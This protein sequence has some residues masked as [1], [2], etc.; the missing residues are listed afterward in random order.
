MSTPS[1][2][3]IMLAIATSPRSAR[4]RPTHSRMDD[5]D[6]AAAADDDDD[7]DAAAAACASI[8]ATGPAG[9]AASAPANVARVRA[10]SMHTQ[11]C[12]PYKRTHVDVATVSRRADRVPMRNFFAGRALCRPP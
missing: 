6:D 4:P 2:T 10:E 1:S 5:D 8:A 7:V 3:H 11:F 12:G 9:V